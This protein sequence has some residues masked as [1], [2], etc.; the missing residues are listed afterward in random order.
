MLNL[1]SQSKKKSV[2]LYKHL[3]VQNYS[4][5][6]SEIWHGAHNF[7]SE[8]DTC[9]RS[10]LYSKRKKIRSKLRNT[11]SNYYKLNDQNLNT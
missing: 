9:S 6:F 10:L 8:F 4:Y 3:D 1:I 2:F 7:F 11:V 5:D